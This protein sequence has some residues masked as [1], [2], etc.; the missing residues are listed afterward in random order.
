MHLPY[1][2]NGEASLQPRW[3]AR[4][5]AAMNKTQKRKSAASAARSR[6]PHAARRTQRLDVLARELQSIPNVGPATAR[7]LIRLGVRGV[8]DLA[9]RDPDA[10]YEAI[11]RLDGAPHDPCVRDVFH[12]AVSFARG[13][14]PRPW[15]EFSRE[16]K[17]KEARTSAAKRNPRGKRRAKNP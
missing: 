13:E 2:G 15:W 9:K 16:R 3:E 17:A 1:F 12:A 11:G 8:A 4:Y 6:R 7:D 14:P 10:M 5:T